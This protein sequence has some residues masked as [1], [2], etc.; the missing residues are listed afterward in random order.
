M[1]LKVVRR[2]W[3]R[4]RG[5]S[6]WQ[7][8][9]VRPAHPVLVHGLLGTRLHCMRWVI[10]KWVKLHLY[11]KMEED[12]PRALLSQAPATDRCPRLRARTEQQ[13]Q[14]GGCW[15]QALCCKTQRLTEATMWIQGLHPF[16]SDTKFCASTMYIQKRDWVWE[17]KHLSHLYCFKLG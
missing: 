7:R 14:H 2:T 11:P 13:A 5:S 3:K 9:E 16:C 15:G 12:R 1:R 10:G 17:T 4:H 6:A 8:G